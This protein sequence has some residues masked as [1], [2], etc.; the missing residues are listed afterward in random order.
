MTNQLESLFKCQSLAIVGASPRETSTARRVLR[1]LARYKYSG[2]V[3]LVNERYDSIDG[4]PCFP[5]IASSGRT[6]DQ[7]LL[8]VPPA[9]LVDAVHDA[10]RSGAKVISVLAAGFAELGDDGALL[11]RELR[12]VVASYG[13]RLLGPNS[14]GVLNLHSGLMAIATTAFD[15]TQLTCGSVSIVSQSGALGSYVT[16]LL[17]ERGVG[18]RYF[19]STGNEADVTMGECLEYMAADAGTTTIVLYAEGFRDADRVVEALKLAHRNGK[20]VV[21]I[22]VGRTALGAAAVRSHTAAMA[23]DDGVY[24]RLF[25]QLGVF[26]ATTLSGVLGAVEAGPVARGLEVVERVAVLTTSGGLGAMVAEQLADAGFDLPEMP[27]EVQR[28]MREVIP[29]CVPLNPID[30]TGQVTVEP[31]K[32][33]E[34]VR[35]ACAGEIDAVV[36]MLAYV[37]LSPRVMESIKAILLEE[38]VTM[39]VPVGIVGSFTPDVAEEL[40]AAGYHVVQ[41]SQEVVEW[42]STLRRLVRLRKSVD[43]SVEL[44]GRMGE[45]TGPLIQLPDDVSFEVL[46]D[47]GLP[48]A[49]WTTHRTDHADG[50]IDVPG[51]PVVVKRLEDGVLHK[52]DAGLIELGV[53]GPVQLAEV[54]ARLEARHGEGGRYLI[55]QMVV[56]SHQ[57]LIVSAWRDQQFGTVFMVGV[58][59]L[60]A[61]FYNDRSVLLPPLSPESIERAVKALRHYP[62]LA[63]MRGRPGVDLDAIIGAVIRLEAAMAELPEVREVEINPL[64]V[65]PRGR[66]AVAVDAVVRVEQC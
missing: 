63:G 55:Q 41:E 12:E 11:E 5:T 46:A 8:L 62:V 53:E 56:G 40:R 50:S 52:S 2:Q 33:R 47:G 1:L 13:M 57:E 64:L 15:S 6:V 42:L 38:A 4:A 26:R 30:A 45:A 58:G 27:G 61:E 19:V 31:D 29:Y 36:I 3:T 54:I 10:G 9:A 37:G 25:D 59:G 48:V 21:A 24:A 28:R 22:K 44:T 20:Q 7:A 18:V 60:L 49:A 17:S 16:S 51:Y 23:G 34:F 39:T 43:T 66:G 65:G 32:F 35:L 14:L